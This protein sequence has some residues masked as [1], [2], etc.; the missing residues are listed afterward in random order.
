MSLL[1]SITLLVIVARMLSDHLT[2]IFMS[3]VLFWAA[4]LL[5]F[6]HLSRLAHLLLSL[7]VHAKVTQCKH[8]PM[9][10]LAA[11]PPSV[12]Y[13][14]VPQFSSA[15]IPLA[16][17]VYMDPSLSK[18]RCIH[19]GKIVVSFRLHWHSLHSGWIIFMGSQ[20]GWEWTC[21]EQNCKRII[22]IYEGGGNAGNRNKSK[23]EERKKSWRIRLRTELD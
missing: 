16:P 18:V 3:A 14:S 11:S 19:K 2:S 4:S 12:S 20:L 10:I 7:C 21:V 13:K 8:S 23:E 22:F 6:G 5:L 15:V 9:R 1:F 17:E